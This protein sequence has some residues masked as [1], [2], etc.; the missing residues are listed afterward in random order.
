MS[1]PVTAGTLLPM[2]LSL[3]PIFLYSSNQWFSSLAI[4]TLILILLI[5]FEDS[6]FLCSSVCFCCWCQVYRSSADEA[7]IYVCLRIDS[8]RGRHMPYYHHL[9]PLIPPSALFAHDSEN[10]K[11]VAHRKKRHYDNVHNEWQ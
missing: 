5:C 6:P 4:F 8:C 7:V 10:S 2:Y 3:S 1:K 9:T 11:N